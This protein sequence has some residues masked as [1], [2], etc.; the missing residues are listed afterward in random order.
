M[1]PEPFANR[2]TL[3]VPLTL[4]L[5][6][7]L[8]LLLVS[9]L[10][11]AAWRLPAVLV[12]VMLP[13]DVTDSVPGTAVVPSTKVLPLMEVAAPVLRLR[14]ILL[15]VV[16]VRLAAVLMVLTDMLP[17]CGVPTANEPT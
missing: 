7:M 12:V 6:A 2:L 17:V 14:V 8:P 15:P 1:A 11:F 4:L 5:M 13:A 10:I 16:K 9:R 3:V